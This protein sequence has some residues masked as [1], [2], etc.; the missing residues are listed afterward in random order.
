[1]PISIANTPHS[2]GIHRNTLSRYTA[3]E[4]IT[5]IAE[6]GYKGVELDAWGFLQAEPEL[7]ALLAAHKL[8]LAEGILP[9]PL[10]DAASHDE[11]EESA[12]ALGALI[13]DLGGT[14]L[15]LMEDTRD[16]PTLQHEAGRVRN[17]RL[18]GTLLETVVHGVERIARRVA[19][20][21]GLRTAIYPQC[22]THIESEA[23]VHNLMAQ[24][25]PDLVG[26]CL[27]TGHW[28]YAGGDA[29]TALQHYGARVWH[30]RFSDCDPYIRQFSLDEQ[31]T[32]YEATQAGVFPELGE[33][34]VNFPA[35]IETL[36]ALHY[37]GWVVVE[38]DTLLNEPDANRV[39][40][41]LNREYLRRLGL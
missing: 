19:E 29:L 28:H 25:D 14:L 34:A 39:T 23:E 6:T 22:A 27:D 38:Q 15:I 31:L 24:L 36:R 1:M 35:I 20:E 11:A 12:L 5:Q 41:R 4:I 2:W 33:G 9:V 13:R 3:A 32:F 30:L 16:N 37:P 7:G 40:A 17:P 26:L 10:T 8:R 21:L 18:T